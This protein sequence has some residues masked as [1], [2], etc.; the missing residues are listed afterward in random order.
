MQTN[1]V[2]GSQFG[3]E[4]K[5]LMSSYL[6]REKDLVV[7][8][9]GGQQA[10]HSV[11]KNGK[12]HIFSN[13]GAGALNNADTYISEFCTFHPKAFFNEFTALKK[14]GCEFNFFI[15][16]MTMVTTPF[17]I[18]H[19]REL[20]NNPETKNGSVGMGFGTTVNRCQNSP[21]KLYVIDLFYKNILKTKLYNIATHYY[22]SYNFEK[23]AIDDTINI[24]LENVEKILGII[25]VRDLSEIKHNYNRINFEGAQGI[26]LDMDF[27][28]FPNVT[29]SNTTSKNAMEIIKQNHLPKPTIH[30]ALRSYL[31][32]HGKGHMPNESTD[33]KFED[34]TNKSHPYQ[35]EFRF[36]YHSLEQLHYAFNVDSIFSNGCKKKLFL[37]C[38]DQTD[39]EIYVENGKST[40]SNFIMMINEC[41]IVFDALLFNNSPNLETIIEPQK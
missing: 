36:G 8:F 31:T 34:L 38:L 32:R 30:Y 16:P 40:I 9:N 6:S 18:L 19:N 1:I 23:N 22:A 4:G 24:F 10:G 25:R 5:G 26:L 28:Y 2:L 33:F 11:V 13:I 21:Y 12:R 39:D 3:D 17:D 41:N 37:T 29:R 27:G 14:L 20:E 15:H 35:G 7:R